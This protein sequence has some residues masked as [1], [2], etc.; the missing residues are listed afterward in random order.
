VRLPGQRRIQLLGAAKQTG[1]D[2][3]QKVL[4]TIRALC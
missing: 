1:L 2:V 3:P 4:D